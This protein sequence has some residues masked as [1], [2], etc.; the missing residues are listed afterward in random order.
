MGLPGK[1][2]SK[3]SKRRR[4]AHFALDQMQLVACKKCSKPILPHRACV[5][6]G[7]Y[8]SRQVIGKSKS[9]VLLKE[10]SKEDIKK[11][12]S[13]KLSSKNKS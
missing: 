1:K 3:S 4:A 6:C 2:L 8:K 7:T 9:E 11:E 5:Y 10:V 12:L 13:S